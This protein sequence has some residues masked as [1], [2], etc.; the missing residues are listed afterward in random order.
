MSFET[1]LSAAGFDAEWQLF[2]MT[3]V[4]HERVHFAN[5]GIVENHSDG[6]PNAP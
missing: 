3:A 5:S 4:A 6:L 1:I 2:Q